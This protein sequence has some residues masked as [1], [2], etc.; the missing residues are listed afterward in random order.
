MRAC[1]GTIAERG[2]VCGLAA[3]DPAGPIFVTSYDGRN[4][5]VTVLVAPRPER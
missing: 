4:L 3:S 5:N 2:Q 1:S